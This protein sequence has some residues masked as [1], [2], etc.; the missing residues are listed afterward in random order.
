MQSIFNGFHKMQI[1]INLKKH[2][3]ET[4]IKKEYE[5]LIKRYFDKKRFNDEKAFI[6]ERIE[7]LK[8]F[9]EHADFSFLRKNYP[10]LN[11]AN[12]LQVVLNIPDQFFQTK[13]VFNNK[14]VTPEWKKSFNS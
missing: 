13:I 1:I 4:E 3:I 7:P 12:D 9:I 10:E 5:R 6:E 8:F 2:C 11:G 14:T